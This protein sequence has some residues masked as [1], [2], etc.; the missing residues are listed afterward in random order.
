MLRTQVGL[1]PLFTCHKCGMEV[2][3]KSQSTLQMVKGWTK[4]GKKT[5]V[6]I[7]DE[8]PIYLHEFCLAT[9]GSSMDTLF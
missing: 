2:D 8:F 1:P 6:K 3:P 5:I 4:S 9:V 7:E